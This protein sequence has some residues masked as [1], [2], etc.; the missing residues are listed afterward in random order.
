MLDDAIYV[1]S[2][3]WVNPERRKVDE[4]LC[5]GWRDLEVTASGHGVSFGGSEDVLKLIL[6]M[7]AQ[8]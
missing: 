3:G 1:N 5:R 7:V 6:V 4:W 2:P 8:L